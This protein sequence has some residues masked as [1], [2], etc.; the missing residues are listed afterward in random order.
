M[1]GAIGLRDVLAY[2]YFDVDT[3]QFT[4]CRVRISQ[5]IETVLQMIKDIK[6]GTT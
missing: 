3:E 1:A 4:I 5:L 2:G 6:D